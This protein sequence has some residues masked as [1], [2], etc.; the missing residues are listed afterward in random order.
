MRPA[1]A[2]EVRKRKTLRNIKAQPPSK[3]GM[4]MSPMRNRMIENP[5]NARHWR[6]LFLLMFSMV[7]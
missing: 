6:T 1:T 7:W 4:T 5:A 3:Q 2:R